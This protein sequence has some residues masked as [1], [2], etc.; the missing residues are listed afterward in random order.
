M[1]TILSAP[2]RDGTDG[3][4]RVS[5]TAPPTS[6]AVIGRRD[7]VY[8]L[9]IRRAEGNRF[10]ASR[11]Q[12][13]SAREHPKYPPLHDLPP[14]RRRP[15][16]HRPRA[17]PSV[18]PSPVARAAPQLLLRVHT[19][20]VNKARATPPLTGARSVF[21]GRDVISS[22][23]PT[24]PLDGEAATFASSPPCPANEYL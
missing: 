1:S 6:R 22:S 19:H 9:K 4:G 2:V 21:C 11:R 24:P 13:R 10:F 16:L 15:L 5:K 3:D 20:A 7:A 23:R 14:D 8:R 17:R 18:C 12:G